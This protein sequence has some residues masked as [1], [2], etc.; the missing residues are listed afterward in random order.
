MLLFR[1]L[2]L[3]QRNLGGKLAVHFHYLMFEG[4]GKDADS[5]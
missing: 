4:C 5:E 1:E 2:V 3:L